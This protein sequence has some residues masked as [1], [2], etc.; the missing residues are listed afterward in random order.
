MPMR[1]TSISTEADK[2]CG[3]AP[4]MRLRNPE[5]CS[6]YG[7]SVVPMSFWAASQIVKDTDG[8]VKTPSARLLSRPS[9]RDFRRQKRIQASEATTPR[10]AR[11]SIRFP[12]E[13]RGFESGLA[14][15]NQT[16]NLAR[17]PA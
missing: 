10:P 1:L 5:I 12:V 2:S 17:L 16:A 8:G 9:E 15:Q 4:V 7:S 3:L 14:L 13:G 11:G 6:T